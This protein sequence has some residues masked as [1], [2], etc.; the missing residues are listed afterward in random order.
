MSSLF[1]PYRPDAHGDP[2]AVTIRELV[3]ADVEACAAIATERN[4]GHRD[5]W[6]AALS[7]GLG[8]P[9]HGGF[10]AV[11]DGDVVGYATAGWLSPHAGGGRRAPDGWYLTGLT[12]ATGFRRRGIGR[13]LTLA[14][15]DWLRGRASEVW[16]FAA[17]TNLASLDLHRALGFEDVTVD[18]EIAG[19][20]FTGGVG[21]LC[22][23]PMGGVRSGA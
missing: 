11:V 9:D 5:A 18:F 4:G 3:G 10:V 12:V 19:V 16:Y 7:G 2:I 20:G 15:L 6:A 17:A 13:A 1:V 23:L 21:V 22:R 8:S 14:R